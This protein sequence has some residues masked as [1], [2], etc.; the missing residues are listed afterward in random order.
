MQKGD[1]L[2]EPGT[3]QSKASLA[4][5]SSIAVLLGEWPAGRPARARFPLLARLLRAM[6][7]ARKSGHPVVYGAKIASS[8]LAASIVRYSTAGHC[9]VVL[10]HPVL[11]DLQ[12]RLSRLTAGGS[13]KQLTAI[14]YPLLAAHIQKAQPQVIIDANPTLQFLSG[15]RRRAA[16]SLFPIITTHHTLSHASELYWL[17]LPLLL[18]DSYRCDSLVCTSKAARGSFLGI[19]GATRERFRARYGLDLKYQGR[20][21]VIPLGVD[22]TLFRPR[23]KQSLRAKLGLQRDALIILCLGRISIVDKA[24]LFPL[25]RVFKELV[26]RFPLKP[27]VMVI[28]GSDYRWYSR[29]VAEAARAL[30]ILDKV[31]I[32]AAY[33]EQPELWYSASDI[34]VSPVDNVQESFGLALIEAMASGLPQVVPDW[35]GYRDSVCHGKTGF[36]VPTYWSRCDDGA[37]EAASLPFRYPPD[38]EHLVLAQSVVADVRKYI[39]YLEAL[40][41]RPDLRAAFGRRSQERAACMYSWPAI[42]AQY[43]SLMLEL[44][45][46]TAAERLARDNGDDFTLPSYFRWFSHYATSVVSPEAVLALTEAGAEIC[47]GEGLTLLAAHP[48]IQW[49]VVRQELLSAILGL[50]QHGALSVEQIAQQVSGW[51]SEEEIQRHVLWLAK[52]GLLGFTTTDSR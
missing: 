13:P 51:T 43:D 48:A 23:E 42:V 6:R 46:D 16:R 36:L 52:Q 10:P 2:K 37:N 22:T 32:E 25:L 11:G 28:A 30:G 5:L 45:S 38:F 12:Q 44:A 14:T 4:G 18:A 34:F 8:L 35:D 24:D 31:R 20:V 3:Q 21:D 19:L 15:V 26:V 40:V 7:P 41:T 29:P 49:E 17:F 27:L 39:E 9:T 1:E 47:R 50:C 33:L